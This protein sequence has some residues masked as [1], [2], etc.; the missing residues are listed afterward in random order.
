[1][2]RPISLLSVLSKILEKVVCVQLTYY[3]ESNSLL[4]PS[5]YAYRSHHS[6]EDAGIDA[7][8]RLISN[9]D[10]GLVSSV[11]A[12]D[13]SKAFDGVDHDAF[14][15]KLPWCGITDVSWFSG[16]L[17]NRT[18]TVRGGGTTLPVTCGVPQGSIIGPIKDQMQ[19][20]IKD[21][22]KD[23]MQKL[24]KLINFSARIVAGVKKHENITPTL[25]SLDWLRIDALV[26]RRDAIK[27]WKLLRVDGVAS[28]VRELLVLWSAVSA[29]ETRD[30]EGGD[31]HL[32]RRRLTS[33]QRAF[34]YRGAAAWNALPRSVRDAPRF[35]VR[36]T[37]MNGNQASARLACRGFLFEPLLKCF[38]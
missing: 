19:N 36:C 35:Q 4:S 32:R 27:V 15:N 29:R 16:Y 33:S 13:L 38:I 37:Y 25:N 7:V 9:T 2:H 28:N 6:T 11:T 8:E 21:Q 18:Q 17:S 5:Q 26:A 31:L 22:N 30:S 34:S 10:R 24:Q 1:M 20:T 23:Q 3:L 14:L 12:I